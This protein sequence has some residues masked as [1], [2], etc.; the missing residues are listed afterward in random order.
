MTKSTDTATDCDCTNLYRLHQWLWLL[1]IGQLANL[2]LEGG[3]KVVSQ[4]WV[5]MGLCVMVPF[6]SDPCKSLCG[7]IPLLRQ[8]DIGPITDECLPMINDLGTQICYRYTP[9]CAHTHTHTH[10]H[11]LCSIISFIIFYKAGTNPWLRREIMIQDC[12][13]LCVQ[14]SL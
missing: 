4:D 12:S 2:S 8:T 11:R 10:T 3:R 13:C 5:S 9:Q 6:V 7:P 14:F 1:L